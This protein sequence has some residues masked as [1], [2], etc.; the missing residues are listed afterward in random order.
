MADDYAALDMFWT[1]GLALRVHVPEALGNLELAN[2]IE[3]L[4]RIVVEFR[5]L[6][7]GAGLSLWRCD[8]A[9]AGATRPLYALAATLDDHVIAHMRR[10]ALLYPISVENWGRLDPADAHLVIDNDRASWDRSTR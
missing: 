9:W 1:L 2:R 10:A 4:D 3:D 6:H 5:T 8:S 7:L